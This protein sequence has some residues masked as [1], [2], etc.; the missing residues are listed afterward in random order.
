MRIALWTGTL[1]LGSAVLAA[2]GPL[3]A[4]APQTRVPSSAEG[5][6]FRVAVD[7]VRIDA[8]VTDKDGRIVRDL[9]AEDFE[10]LQDGKKQTIT[11]ARFVPVA[12]PT[13]AATVPRSDARSGREGGPPAPPPLTAPA[14]VKREH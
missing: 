4:Q 5:P 13:A 2:H 8:V 1:V 11:F 9:T 12:A 10:I 6:R 14:T 7:A 3:A